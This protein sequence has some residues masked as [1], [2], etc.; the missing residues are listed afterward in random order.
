MVGCVRE[1][2]GEAYINQHLCLARQTGEYCSSFL[3]YYLAS[4]LGSLKQLTKIQRGVTKPGL[5]LSDIRSIVFSTP[6][7]DEQE[8]I[9]RHID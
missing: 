3:A 8:E 2:I 1:D 6:E 4:P 5:T 9:V 7:L